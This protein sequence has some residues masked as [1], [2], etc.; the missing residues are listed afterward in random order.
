MYL[1]YTK[2]S[3]ENTE[4]F[5]L[6]H[7]SHTEYIFVEDKIPEYVK[8]FMFNSCPNNKEI[9][10]NFNNYRNDTIGVNIR[11]NQLES[12]LK[13]YKKQSSELKRRI[14]IEQ[15]TP[16]EESG[17]KLDKLKEELNFMETDITELE[18]ILQEMKNNISK[19]GSI[20][21]PYPPQRTSLSQYQRQYPHPNYPHPN[22]PHP[23]Y[24]HPNYPYIPYNPSYNMVQNKEKVQKSKLSFYITIELDLFPGTSANMSQKH[25]VKCQSTFE[26]VREAWTDIFGF[27]YKKAPMIEAYSYQNNKEVNNKEDKTQ[28]NTKI[29]NNKTKNT[30]I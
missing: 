10:T 4:K 26:R 6:V 3:I 12:N 13:D 23:N 24:P 20:P 25:M 9:N 28:K 1:V 14:L 5:Q 21:N 2:N 18:K 15:L 11:M 16:S 29:R 27:Q 30:K 22:Y 8:Y 19:G 17:R 7:Y